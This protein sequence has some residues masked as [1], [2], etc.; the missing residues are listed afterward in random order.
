MSDIGVLLDKGYNK[1]LREGE[2]GWLVKSGQKRALSRVRTARRNSRRLKCYT[3]VVN[4]TSARGPSAR[5]VVAVCAPAN[6]PTHSQGSYGDSKGRSLVSK[7][8]HAPRG[9]ISV[10]ASSEKGRESRTPGICRV[11]KSSLSHPLVLPPPSPSLACACF[12][13]VSSVFQ[14]PERHLSDPGAPSRCTEK[15]VRSTGETCSID[16]VNAF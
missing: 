6:A 13:A 16:V 7:D 12:L 3:E 11:S 4:E 2:G 9:S 5:L 10:V 1:S 15:R 14:P 8:T